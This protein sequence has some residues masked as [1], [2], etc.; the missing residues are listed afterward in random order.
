MV[1]F[2]ENSFS[3]FLIDGSKNSSLIELDLL[4]GL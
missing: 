2:L 1:A 3:D 4:L